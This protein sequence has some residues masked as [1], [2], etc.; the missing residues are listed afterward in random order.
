MKYLFYPGCSQDSSALE[1]KK[2]TLAVMAALGA[3][4]EE[5]A[6][7]TCCGASAAAVMSD[8]LGLVLPARNLALAEQ[9]GAE[10]DILVACSACYTNFRATA[11]AVEG[12]PKLLAQINRALEVEGVTYHGQARA[13]HVMDI[14]ANDFTVEE[15]KARVVRPLEG[16]TVAPYYGCQTVR[17]YSPY[18]DDQRPTSMEAVIEALGATVYHHTRTATCCGTSLLMTKPHVGYTM[19]GSILEACAPADCVAVVCPMCHMNL[20]SYQ[21]QTSHA[22]GKSLH[23]PIIF[24]PQLMGLAFGLSD[25]DLLFKR[26]VVSVKPVLEKLA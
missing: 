16:L 17:P 19:V 13:R 1:Y 8:L 2:S 12:K 10:L 4:V 9:A 23:I 5:L 25:D 20:D 26:H 22:V 15:I 24:L 6:D 18:D 14:L 21:D 11:A 7:W 3:E